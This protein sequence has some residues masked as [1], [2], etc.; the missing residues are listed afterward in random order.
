MKPGRDFYPAICCT[1]VLLCLYIFFFYD[2]VEYENRR[3]VASLEQALTYNQFSKHM[4]IALF[5]QILVMIA[6]RFVT[7]YNYHDPG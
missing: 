4:V 3:N 5:L 6:D 2:M 7:T 1:Q